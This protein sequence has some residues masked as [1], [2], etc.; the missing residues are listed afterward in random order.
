V[1]VASITRLT[2]ILFVVDT[3][4]SNAEWI[5]LQ[6][7]GQ[8]TS[9]NHFGCVA[10]TDPDKTFRGGS[11][12]SFLTK[13][14][15]KSNFQWGFMTFGDDTTV[16]YIGGYG[17]PSFTADPNVMQGAL[18]EFMNTNDEGD[19][20]YLL[21]IQAAQRAIANDR[22]NGTAANPQYFVVMLTDGYPTDITSAVQAAPYITSLLNTAHGASNLS[23]IFY[24]SQVDPSTAGAL[25]LLQSMAT[26]GNGQFAN[27]TQSGHGIINID[28]VIPG[29]ACP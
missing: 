28:N 4:G 23:T 26:M 2:K 3:T 15:G 19:T 11:I 5:D 6:T 24:G 14:G 9:R 8:C 18:N 29:V 27:A 22:D 25:S 10:P 13:Y 1:P 20:P 12:Q 7:Q 16:D 17:S 21:A